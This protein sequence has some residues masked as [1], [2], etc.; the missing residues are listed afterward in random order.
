MLAF[1]GGVRVELVEE[2]DSFCWERRKRLAKWEDSIKVG[3]ST[4]EQSENGSLIWSQ[5]GWDDLLLKKGCV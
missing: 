5:S 4:G 2:K 3:S 1:E